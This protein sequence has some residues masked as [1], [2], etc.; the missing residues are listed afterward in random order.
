MSRAAD[1][2]SD[3]RPRTRERKIFQRGDSEL[4]CFKQ[5][6]CVFREAGVGIER[7]LQNSAA[8][9]SLFALHAGRIIKIQDSSR[10]GHGGEF[11]L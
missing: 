1:Q 3:K 7:A 4:E 11:A 6:S 8:T 5:S 2:T 10:G 9:L